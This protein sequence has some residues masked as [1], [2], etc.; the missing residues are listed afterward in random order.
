MS[1]VINVVVKNA[2]STSDDVTTPDT[3]WYT[4]TTSQSASTA[5]TL[6]IMAGVGFLLAAA[7]L[8]MVFSKKKMFNTKNRTK[9]I[10]YFFVLAALALSGIGTLVSAI[11]SNVAAKDDVIS[12]TSSDTTITVV[13]PHMA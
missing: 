4:S 1:N 2:D 3:G 6:P 11:T 7:M 10:G 8:L 13:I 5:P 9:K 12:F